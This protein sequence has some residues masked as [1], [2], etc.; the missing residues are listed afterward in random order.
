M[1]N[2]S[3]S[4]LRKMS[5]VTVVVVVVVRVTVLAVCLGEKEGK[6]EFKLVLMKSLGR[7]TVCQ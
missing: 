4:F 2:F 5:S 1:G 3:E 7:L 6:C